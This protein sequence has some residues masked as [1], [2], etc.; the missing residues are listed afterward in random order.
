MKHIAPD[1]ATA[2]EITHQ[3]SAVFGKIS[4]CNKGYSESA[5]AS[6]L[7]GTI[8]KKIALRAAERNDCAILD[9]K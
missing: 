6:W 5:K 9:K 2:A 1:N 7:S 3:K 8:L 4:L